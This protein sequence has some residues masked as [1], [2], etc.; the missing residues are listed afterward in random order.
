METS[1]IEELM[2]AEESELLRIEEQ[3]EKDEQE[4][5]EYEYST[6]DTEVCTPPFAFLTSP[7]RPDPPF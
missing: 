4:E 1:L 7:I 3:M 5:W 6:T 2:L